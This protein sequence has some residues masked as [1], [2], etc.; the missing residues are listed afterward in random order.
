MADNDGDSDEACTL[1]PLQAA[2]CTYRDQHTGVQCLNDCSPA[3]WTRAIAHGASLTRGHGHALVTATP[4]GVNG[5]HDMGAN[6]WER[7]DEPA[8]ASGNA[9]RRAR[10]GTW[11][12]GYAQKRA[13]CLQS[14]P[15]D[16]AATHIGFRCSQTG[17]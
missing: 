14:K 4:A 7:V 10:G 2:A 8:G 13:D 6:A 11:W 9:E 1:R 16:T 17:F 5:L 15:A 12:Y 3:A